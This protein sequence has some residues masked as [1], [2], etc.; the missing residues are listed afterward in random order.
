MDVVGVPLRGG[1]GPGL[2]AAVAQILGAE[3][4]VAGAGFLV[5]EGVL[6]TCAH[7]VTAGGYGP[8]DRLRLTFPHA[9]GAP[10]VQGQ[11]LAEAWRAPE[12]QDVAVVRLEEAPGGVRALALGSAAGCQGHRVRSFGF[13][14]Q[15]PP[16]GHFG[17]GVAG[18]PLPAG[19]GAG[20]VLQLTD[21][22]D[23]TT[24]FSGGPVVDEVTGLVIGMVTAIT[25]PDAHLK[26]LG[27]AYATP[28]QVLREVWPDLVEQEVC[29]YRGLEPFTGEHAEWFHGRDAAIE[30]VLAGLAEHRHALLLGPSGSGKSSLIQAGVLPALAAGGLPGSDRW[31]PVLTRPGQD[32]WAELERADLPRAGTDGIV[33]AAE[34]RLAAEPAYQRMLL[35]IDQ[36]EELLTQPSSGP[37][38]PDGLL[39]ALEQITAV[40]SSHTA[41]SVILV[42]R[43]DFY[44]R[45]AALAPDLLDAAAPGLL[46]VPATLSPQ[47]LQAIITLPAHAAGAHFEE[48]LP[49]RIIANL[50]ANGHTGP[51]ARRTPVTLLPPLELALSQLWERRQD[52]YLT[53]QAYHDIGEVT[54]S[55]ATWCNTALD[56]L[57]AT[58][59]PTAQRILTALVRPAD[60]TH[61]I[62]A[63]RQQLPLTTLRDLATDTPSDQPASQ[64]ID[65]VIAA[66]TRHRIITTHTEHTAGQPH[67]TPGQPVAELIH[68]AL[69]RDWTEL[70]HW[71]AQDHQFHDWLRRAGEQRDRW[72]ER[73]NPGDLLHGTDLAEGL[74][75]SKQRSLP[76]DVAAF[77]TASHQR[78]QAAIRRTRRLNA[79]LASALVVAVIAAG[80]SLWQ[81]QTAITAQRVAESRQLAAQSTALISGNPDLASLLAIQAYR[82]SHTTEATT[83]L[84]AAAALPLQHVLFHYHPVYTLAFSPDGRT[85]AT[86][87][88]NG[89]AQLLDVATLK[90]RVTLTGDGP[91][92]SVAFSP[93][94]HTLATGSDDGPARLWDVATGKTRTTLTGHD[95]PVFS[96]AFSPDG[97]TLATGS[98]D[99]TARLWDV[100]TGKTRT[101]LTG[102]DSPVL[103]VAFS[104][105]GRTLATSSDNGT[106]RLWEVATGKT[107]TILTG[108]ATQ[109]AFSRDGTLATGSLDGTAQLWDV[110]TGKTR[111]TLTGHNGSV[112]T[113]AFSPD[114]HTLATGSLDGTVQLWE[115]ATGQART[116]P[117]SHTSEVRSL[118]FSPDGH[119]L[120][121]SSNDGTARL[122]DVAATGQ[123]RTT[124]PGPAES[125]AFSPDG[126][127]L[128][129]SSKDG[130]ARLWEVATGKTRTTLTGSSVAFSPDGHTLATGSL[131]GTAR[132]W[133]VATGKTRTTLTGHTST[134][135]SVAFSPD[136]HTLATGSND[137]TARLWDVATGKTRVTLTGH[138]SDGVWSVAFSPDGHTLATGS[139]YGR[140]RLWDVATGK[141]RAT[142]TGSSVAFSPD[143]HTLATGRGATARLWDVATGKT[144]TTLTDQT[145]RT[146][147]VLTVAFSPDGRTLA[148]GGSSV[149]NNEDAP[150]RLWDVATGQART[151]RT[152]HTSEV[153]SVAFSPDGHTLAT[154][155]ADGTWLWDIALPDQ[156]GAISKICQTIHRDLTPEE[157]SVYLPGQSPSPVCPS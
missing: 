49:E 90:T 60:D 88:D 128:A 120:A 45:L 82:T 125:V 136:G 118:A 29:P 156:D 35:V 3:G 71:V 74:G 103:S 6:V 5:A 101:T 98:D 105:D 111:T 107:R 134:V 68:D 70:R 122:W 126:H 148:T 113:L 145:G 115:V 133:D 89:T 9:P 96:V 129:T 146:Y 84:Y 18:D 25:S 154:G 123:P 63:V 119:T 12:D 104:P 66:L 41:L 147:D 112:Y 87:S 157:R 33:A 55:L 7:V 24:G 46:N 99:G 17:Y 13:P 117:T 110:A 91:A 106:A 52:G 149:D 138:T 40:I 27:I 36:F 144:R 79:F 127:T 124:L 39:N 77:L 47:D 76:R 150:A 139:S 65:E 58:Q 34:R 10:Q 28:T 11:V 93:D 100:A 62:P 23:L 69:I 135:R 83:S 73:E 86:S 155:S 31:L 108:T 57:P 121:T 48:G 141:T 56:H 22:N 14:A 15:A 64:T 37:Q 132:L 53:H 137:G 32:L 54:G 78:Q 72:A 94:G 151:T 143:G 152:G 153:R 97:R 80:V 19:A 142:L 16:G 43:D 21:A 4:D 131:D 67:T 42:M 38:P 81:W 114:G 26:G 1:S 92:E 102:H 59:R 116:T 8:G 109:V 75:W 51:A 130:V 20:A 44:P 30:R 95:S 140:A 2:P 61:L 50:L 85:L